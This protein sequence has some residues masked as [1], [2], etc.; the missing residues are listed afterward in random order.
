MKPKAYCRRVQKSVFAAPHVIQSNLAFDIITENICYINGYLSLVDNFQLHISEY[1]ITNPKI[2]RLK[3]RYH[4]QTI[5]H[6]FIARWDNASH[7]PQISTHPHHLHLAH[8]EIVSSPTMDIEQVLS[9]IL[10]FLI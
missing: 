5:E 8:G 1:V 4:L 10:P 2:K 6:K 3:Y 7:H 9:A